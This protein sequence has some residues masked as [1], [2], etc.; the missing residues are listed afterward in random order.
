MI[1]GQ[2]LKPGDKFGDARVVKITEN[3]VVLRN[4]QEVQT[5]KLFP[6]VEKQ[7]TLRHKP[8]KADNRQSSR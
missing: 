5:V 8:S 2:A 4:G 1:D 6:Q 7:K 3:E